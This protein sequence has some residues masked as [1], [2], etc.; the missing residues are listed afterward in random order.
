MTNLTGFVGRWRIVSMGLW[1]TDAIDL[2][3]PGFIEFDPDGTGQFG[4]IA[5]HG[6]MDCRESTRDNGPARVEFTWEGSDE[7]RPTG[8]RGWTALA[9]DGTIDG[10]TFFHLGDD[11]AFRGVPEPAVK[12]SARRRR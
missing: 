11:S 6:W 2:V 10:H 7:G 5:V 8:G 9:D 4:F 1:D 12:R 3:G